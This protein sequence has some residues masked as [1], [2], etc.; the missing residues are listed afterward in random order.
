MFCASCT[1]SDKELALIDSIDSLL[2]EAQ[3]GGRL[4]M[5]VL[6]SVRYKLSRVSCFAE[7]YGEMVGFLQAYQRQQSRKLVA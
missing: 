1:D 4:D 5:E 7:K 3:D 6:R 2:T